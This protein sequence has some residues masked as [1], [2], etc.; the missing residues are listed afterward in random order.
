MTSLILQGK[1][2]KLTKNPFKKPGMSVEP[3]Q[4]GYSSDPSAA[5]K[6][7]DSAQN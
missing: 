4:S 2:D 6:R 7:A 1:L 5:L 3:D